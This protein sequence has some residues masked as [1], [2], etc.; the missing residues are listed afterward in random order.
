[1]DGLDSTLFLSAGKEI[2]PAL[3]SNLARSELSPTHKIVVEKY[4]NNIFRTNFGTVTEY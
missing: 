2:F 1:M 4:N 3:S